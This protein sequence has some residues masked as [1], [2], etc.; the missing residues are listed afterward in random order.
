MLVCLFV[1]GGVGWLFGSH[2]KRI[3]TTIKIQ[4]IVKDSNYLY[5]VHV[6]LY[7]FR[8]RATFVLSIFSLFNHG[9][10]EGNE[11][12]EGDEGHEGYEGDEES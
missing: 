7:S 4:I 2:I 10:H 8:T 5:N 11:G 3:S 1:G 12:H 6:L 9:S